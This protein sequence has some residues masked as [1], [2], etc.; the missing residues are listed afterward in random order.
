MVVTE[1]PGER[2]PS[3]QRRVHPAYL[4]FVFREAGFADVAVD[5]GTVV[6]TR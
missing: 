2:D 4:A 3:Y 6:A 5:A 1:G